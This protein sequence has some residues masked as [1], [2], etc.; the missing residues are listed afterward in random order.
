[1][2]HT[3]AVSTRFTDASGAVIDPTNS[4]NQ[5]VIEKA[6]RASLRAFEDNDHDGDDDHEE[7]GGR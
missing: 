1:M 4:A 7:E 3:S 5:T 2:D 6:I